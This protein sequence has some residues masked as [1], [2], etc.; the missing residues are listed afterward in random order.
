M[1]YAI[2]SDTLFFTVRRTGSILEASLSVSLA[3][4]AMIRKMEGREITM[5]RLEYVPQGE[6]ERTIGP[7]RS[8]ARSSASAARG[9][10]SL[11]RRL[12]STARGREVDDRSR[13]RQRLAG[14]VG[15]QSRL[16]A[17]RGRVRA[18]VL[19]PTS[20]AP[21]AIGRWRRPSCRCARSATSSATLQADQFTDKVLA[22][23][24]EFLHEHQP[25]DKRLVK[26]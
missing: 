6:A 4:A 26:A 21:A 19:S 25:A 9:L 15:P 8:S 17:Q 18:E 7:S 5:D 2:K 10:H 3:D 22:L 20:A 13:N 12:L 14:D 1:L 11:R 24:L 16:L 23:A